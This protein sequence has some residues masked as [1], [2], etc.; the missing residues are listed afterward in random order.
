MALGSDCT[1]VGG[2][3]ISL[4]KQEGFLTLKDCRYGGKNGADI[5]L[6]GRRERQVRK[7]ILEFPQ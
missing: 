3:L 5:N 6:K 1:K 2:G 4:D 7:D